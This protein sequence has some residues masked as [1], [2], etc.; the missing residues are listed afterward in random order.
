MTE[1]K[2]HHRNRD[3]ALLERTETIEEFTAR[4]REMTPRQFAQLPQ[5][6]LQRLTPDQRANIAASLVSAAS[7]PAKPD[8]DADRTMLR[9]PSSS[10][11]PRP[12]WLRMIVTSFGWGTTLSLM[13]I[14]F[15]VAPPLLH[16]AG[17]IERPFES[18][19]WPRCQRLTP[20]ADGC[21]YRVSR[22]ISWS[23]AASL[24]NMQETYLRTINHAPDSI[25]L[26]AGQPIVV[27]RGHGR[28]IP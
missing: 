13:A 24:L 23:D 20:K 16:R 2:Q 17:Q 12:I 5:N 7:D 15:F 4:C 8:I 14:G 28:L 11:E 3:R 18:T 27:W 6:L 1:V 21:V 10:R 9:Q 26:T 25:S 19:H 22:A